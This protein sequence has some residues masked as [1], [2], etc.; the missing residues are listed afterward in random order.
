MTRCILSS[1]LGRSYLG[2]FQNEN[3]VLRPKARPWKPLSSRALQNSQEQGMLSSWVWYKV[4]CNDLSY[5]GEQRRA[6]MFEWR[7]H[8]VVGHQKVLNTNPKSTIYWIFPPSWTPF[9]SSVKWWL[10]KKILL[11]RLLGRF[12]VIHLVDKY[13]LSAYNVP[14]NVLGNMMSPSPYILG[15]CKNKRLGGWRPVSK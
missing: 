4:R 13:L 3:K 6:V 1:P 7:D 11:H 15:L 9:Y 14:D 5:A 10:K 8:N 12:K 2:M